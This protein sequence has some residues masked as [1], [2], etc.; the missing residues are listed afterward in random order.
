MPPDLTCLWADD[1]DQG[2]E[3]RENGDYLFWSFPTNVIHSNSRI[4]ITPHSSSKAVMAQFDGNNGVEQLR[5]PDDK[6]VESMEPTSGQK[7]KVRD[8]NTI[9]QGPR[10]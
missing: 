10:T 6:G 8:C 4:N 9:L 7:P 2:L 5:I 3:A 1:G